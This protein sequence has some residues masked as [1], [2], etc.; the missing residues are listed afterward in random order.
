MAV[1]V[2]VGF[3]ARLQQLSLIGA[4]IAGV[5]ND[6][7]HKLFSSLGAGLDIRGEEDG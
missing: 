1:T 6:D 5:L 3:A 7:S 2:S 4:A